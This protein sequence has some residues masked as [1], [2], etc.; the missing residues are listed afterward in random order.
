[1]APRAL[2]GGTYSPH[3]YFW[4]DQDLFVRAFRRGAANRATHDDYW[5]QASEL[6]PQTFVPSSSV[7]K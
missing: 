3:P 6:G 1:M 2:Y 4:P 7:V 5:W